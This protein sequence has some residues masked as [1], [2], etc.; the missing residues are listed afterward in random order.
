MNDL[1]K[2]IESLSA[3]DQASLLAAVEYNRLPHQFVQIGT[4]GKVSHFRFFRLMDKGLVLTIPPRVKPE[5]VDIVRRRWMSGIH[6]EISQPLRPA[7]EKEP[8]ND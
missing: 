3:C 2:K 6:P 1:E 4:R 7:N 5:V 8:K